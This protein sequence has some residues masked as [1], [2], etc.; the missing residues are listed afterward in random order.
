M[1]RR[2]TLSLLYENPYLQEKPKWKFG[3]RAIRDIDGKY[4]TVCASINVG[5]NK[6]IHKT[7]LFRVIVVN[8]NLSM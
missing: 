4:S 2:L 6:V 8:D 3:Q 7:R 1:Y 5:E